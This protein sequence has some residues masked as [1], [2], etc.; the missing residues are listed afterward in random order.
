MVSEPLSEVVFADMAIRVGRGAG[1][2]RPV[3]NTK[4]LG[5]LQRV[6]ARIDAMERR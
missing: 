3:A 5:M 4:V 2:R 1:K 6:E